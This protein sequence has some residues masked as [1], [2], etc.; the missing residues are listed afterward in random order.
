M[1]SLDNPCSEDRE[2]T[3]QAKEGLDNVS[4]ENGESGEESPDQPT[5]PRLGIGHIMLW[6][7]GSAVILG[8]YRAGADISGMLS[9]WFWYL[10]MT[11]NSITYGAAVSAVVLFIYWRLTSGPTFPV[12]PGH[13]LLLIPGALG[14]ANFVAYTSLSLV[15][16]WSTGLPADLM[17][18]AQLVFPRIAG[19][20]LCVVAAVRLIDVRCWRLYFWSKA[21]VELLQATMYVHI[22]G[23]IEFPSVLSFVHPIAVALGSIVLFIWLIVAIV[24][25]WRRRT[26][27]DW[28]HWTGIAVAFSEPI[29]F[30]IQLAW[31]VHW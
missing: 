13:W 26:Q 3:S 20:V 6:T 25:D 30:L 7:A 23:L 5:R 4:A 11:V 8:I 10:K 27:R 17:T 29:L 31:L 18:V 16:D 1:S 22:F 2:D 15:S 21:I 12:Q 24:L 19:G 9:D 14:I 28:L